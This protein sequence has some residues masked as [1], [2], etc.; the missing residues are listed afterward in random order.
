MGLDD[1]ADAP[2]LRFGERVDFGTRDVH[3]AGDAEV[4]V[5]ACMTGAV[6][7]TMGLIVLDEKVSDK[8]TG[9]APVQSVWFDVTLPPSVPT[10][11]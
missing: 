8:L 1:G 11:M 9:G 4:L 5:L 7:F 6:F 3:L 10:C 2:A